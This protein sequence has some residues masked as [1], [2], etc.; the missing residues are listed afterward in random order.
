MPRYYFVLFSNDGFMDDVEGTELPDLAAARHE[1]RE[2]VEYLRQRRIGGRRSWAGWEMQVRDDG[3][4]VLLV[5]P[6]SRSARAKRRAQA[7]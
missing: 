2:D 3:G 6:F 5:V 4:A 1:A 7:I